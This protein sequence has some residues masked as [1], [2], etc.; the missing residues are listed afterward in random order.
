[1]LH[2]EQ[3]GTSVSEAVRRVVEA[4][5][6]LQ[7]CLTSG[8]VNYSELARKLQPIL[9]SILGRAVSIDAIKMA[10]I[11]YADKMG[12]NK[13]VE[14]GT[15]VLEV[16]AR[17]ELEIRTGITVATFS[18]SVLP[19]IIEMARQLVGKARFFA[20][21]QALTTITIIMDNESFEYIKKLVDE[22]HIVHVMRDQVA[23]IIVSPIEIIETPGVLAYI[24]SILARN[25][26]NIVQVASCHTDTVLIISKNDLV[27]T[28]QLLNEVIELAR[29]Y[30]RA[31]QLSVQSK[32]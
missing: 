29:Q 20:I 8:I 14:F 12:R 23:V 11:R 7:E 21:M 26:V 2:L 15:R 1:M 25:N 10:L 16:L 27:R 5:P 28:F 4:N 32:Q 18:I 24:T 6:S 3:N 17:S 13:L 9:T 31:L 19:Q 30:L 22:R